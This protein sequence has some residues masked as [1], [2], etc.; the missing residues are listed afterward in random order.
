MDSYKHLLKVLAVQDVILVSPA[1]SIPLPLHS[2]AAP[3]SAFL[4]A[5]S[6]AS[7]PSS[8]TPPPPIPSSASSLPPPASHLTSPPP[9]PPLMTSTACAVFGVWRELA[10]PEDFED[11]I[12]ARNPTVFTLRANPR[13]RNTHQLELVKQSHTLNFTLVVEQWQVQERSRAEPK[14]EPKFAFKLGFCHERGR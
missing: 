9:P 1:A 12:I 7:S 6:P 3:N 8:T 14:Q 10:P 5:P 11:S 2:T 4:T 13:E